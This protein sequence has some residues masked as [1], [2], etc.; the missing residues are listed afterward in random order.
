M[1]TTSYPQSRATTAAR[2][3]SGDRLAA[4]TAQG[5]TAGPTVL[6]VSRQRDGLYISLSD[7]AVCNWPA[8]ERVE[9]VA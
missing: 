3:R 9:I 7:G 5:L 4:Y 6:G 1:T 8:N 2:L